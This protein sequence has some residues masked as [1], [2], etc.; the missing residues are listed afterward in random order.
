MAGRRSGSKSFAF[1]SEALQQQQPLFYL[2]AIGI[3]AQAMPGQHPVAGN[4]DGE[5]IGGHGPAYSPRCAR[6]T[7]KGGYLAVGHA[8]AARY[9]RTI[10]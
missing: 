1:L 3:A 2:L 4:E 6:L 8:A 5:R 10:S 9:G 7:R